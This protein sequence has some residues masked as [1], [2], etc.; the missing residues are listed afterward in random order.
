MTSSTNVPAT[1]PSAA[2]YP[3]LSRVDSPADL[4]RMGRPEL[5]ALASELYP[6]TR[7]LCPQ[8]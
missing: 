6:K 3:L 8:H 2:A 7:Q 4:R 5:K 1:L